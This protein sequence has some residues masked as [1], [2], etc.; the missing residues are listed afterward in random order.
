MA[1]Q[2]PV[3]PDRQPQ[4]DT[5]DPGLPIL[6]QPVPRPKRPSVITTARTLTW[7]Q[8]ALVMICGNCSFG[9]ALQWAFASAAEYFGIAADPFGFG[10]LSAW[11][12]GFAAIS[13]YAYVVHRWSGRADRRAR[14]T[15]IIGTAVLV[16][17]TA[18]AIPVLW[19]NVGL[20]LV[21]SAPSL[22]LQAIVVECVYCREGRRWFKRERFDRV[23]AEP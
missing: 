17:C 3:N 20:V 22:I 15:I 5:T 14:T 16:G 6:V 7:I 4:T 12:I 8:V 23:A 9:W 10:V 11:A 13:T 1:S 19:P 2:D 21:A 18:V